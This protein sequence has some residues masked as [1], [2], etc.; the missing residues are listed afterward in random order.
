MERNPLCLLARAFVCELFFDPPKGK[1]GSSNL[2][3]DTIIHQ[4]FAVRKSPVG[5][6]HPAGLFCARYLVFSNA[7]TYSG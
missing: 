1:V 7:S 2:P 5:N 3:W 4:H 6:L